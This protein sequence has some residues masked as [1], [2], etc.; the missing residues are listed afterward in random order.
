M[1]GTKTYEIIA[2][3]LVKN[4]LSSGGRI[5]CDVMDVFAF[6]N[7]DLAITAY[8]IRYKLD[9]ADDFLGKLVVFFEEDLDD[10]VAEY[11]EEVGGFKCM[12]LATKWYRENR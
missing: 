7:D 1:L 11:V 12:G 10:V 8:G 6:L 4:I 3:N 2:T 5:E 9:T